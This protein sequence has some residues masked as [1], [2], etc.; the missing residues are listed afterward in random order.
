MALVHDL[1]PL[2]LGAVTGRR[3]EGPAADYYRL[4]APA[5]A[6]GI[7]GWAIGLK[8]G[9]SLLTA[10]GPL[11]GSDWGSAAA[12]GSAATGSAATGGA[13]TRVRAASWTSRC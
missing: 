7:L 6:G 11:H 13:A 12:T 1:L 9:R 4:A 2:P 5:T 3:V 10:P 8:A